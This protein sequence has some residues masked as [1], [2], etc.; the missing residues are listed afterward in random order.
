VITNSALLHPAVLT[1]LTV[2][3][4][5]CEGG[6]PTSTPAGTPYVIGAIFPLSGD[7]ARFGV[8]QLRGVKAAEATINREGG[9]GGHRLEI[10]VEDDHSN[11]GQTLASA[12]DLIQKHVIALIGPETTSGCEAVQTLVGPSGLVEFCLA[13]AVQPPRDS[14][15]W[16]ASPPVSVV[17]NT[18]VSYLMTEGVG[19]VALL[20]TSDTDGLAGVSA[21][22]AAIRCAGSIQVVADVEYQA[23]SPDISA[24]LDKIKSSSAEA[25][26][27]WATRAP[28][29]VALEGIHQLSINIPVV[30]SNDNA[31]YSF[32][33]ALAPLQVSKLLMPATADV[34]W[35]QAPLGISQFKI[36]QQ[37]HNDFAKSFTDIPAYG[38]GS[39]YDS[40]IIL[41]N[42]VRRA[43]S[44]PAAI[45][46]YLSSANEVPGV[47]GTYDFTAH[48]HIALANPELAMVEVKQT[49]FHAVRP[50]GP[51]LPCPRPGPTP[52]K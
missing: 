18:I 49:G 32:L 21:T 4:I 36:E 38:S 5:A 1:L 14:H 11:P 9:I 22:R 40:T 45:V 2:F 48:S 35:D 24:Q 47:Q 6:T 28:A 16:L 10:D 42:V 26:I 17:A 39:G 41:A 30:T 12:V 15:V 3:L 43:G 25:I 34:W 50:P 44:D 8:D 37:F 19:R 23:N 33:S 46:R 7:Q 51:P 27:L 52:T 13:P 31:S 29:L 20:A